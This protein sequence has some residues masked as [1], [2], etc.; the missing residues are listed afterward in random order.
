MASFCA[1]PGC[2][3]LVLFGRC[4][5]HQRP[6]T[7]K[8][9]TTSEQGYTSRWD[10]RARRF[11][12]RYPLCGMRPDCQPAVMSECYEQD[13]ITRATCVDHVVPHHGDQGLFWDELHNWQS[14]CASCHFRKTAA[15]L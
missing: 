9:L 5:Q 14:L 11:R 10:T 8:G 6:H 2:G 3:A 1:E 13:R 4:A 12:A 15:G 7:P